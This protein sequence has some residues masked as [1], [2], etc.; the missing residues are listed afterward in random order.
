MEKVREIFKE[1]KDLGYS[2][3]EMEHNQKNALCCGVSSWMNCNEKSKALRYKRM[4]EAKA[5]GD[6]MVT[7]CPKCRLHLTCL[8]ADYEDVASVEILDFSEFLINH[9]KI[10]KQ[11]E[12]KK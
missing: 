12:E 11:E 1:F 7:S 6:I 2:F 4:V 10:N 5:A 8:A 3:N 9:I